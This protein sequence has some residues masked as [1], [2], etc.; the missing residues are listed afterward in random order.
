MRW[1]N[2]VSTTLAEVAGA[3]A[4]KVG[5]ST[6]EKGFDRGSDIRYGEATQ[7][8]L[9]VKHDARG[10]NKE[11]TGD[12][13]FADAVATRPFQADIGAHGA[14]ASG[15]RGAHQRIIGSRRVEHGDIGVGADLLAQKALG[16]FFFIRGVR[17]RFR[18]LRQVCWSSALIVANDL[19]DVRSPSVQCLFAFAF[20]EEIVP[21]ALF[22]VFA[23]PAIH[24][25]EPGGRPLRAGPVGWE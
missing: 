25:K 6:S 19:R 14:A 20:G 2:A 16:E 3:Q 24:C 15:Q 11:V 4:E 13:G 8:R 10:R 7:R 22:V 1:L 21:L 12:Q 17:Y 18:V 23:G 9:E 5:R